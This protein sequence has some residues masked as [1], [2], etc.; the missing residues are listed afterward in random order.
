MLQFAKKVV[1]LLHEDKKNIS[2]ITIRGLKFIMHSFF[3][4]K[5]KILMKRRLFLQIPLLSIPFALQ[6]QP[7]QADRLKKAIKVSSGE[8]RFNKTKLIRG[9][10]EMDCKVSGKDTNGEMS[11]FENGFSQ[12]GGPG[13]HLHPNQDEW[14]HVME[15]VFD[16]KIGEETFRL[17]A[18]DSLFAPRKVPHAF[19]FVGE[20]HGKLMLVYQPAG[21]MEDYYSFVSK[22]TSP[23]SAEEIK[24]IYHDHGMELVGTE[25]PTGE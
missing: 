15:G 14:F 1:L 23:P 24:K 22:L 3:K 20:G 2:V 5:N 12:K 25:L 16:F 21:K 18:G 9:V 7:K 6:T 8:D 17:K 13:L 19:A 4:Q 10:F 11:V